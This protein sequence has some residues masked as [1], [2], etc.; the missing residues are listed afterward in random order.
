ML[1]CTLCLSNIGYRKET[2]NETQMPGILLKNEIRYRRTC[3]QPPPAMYCQ[4]LTG[5]Q[6]LCCC[7][8][9][10]SQL[11]TR[12]KLHS[13]ICKSKTVSLSNRK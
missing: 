12:Y 4:V 7:K 8:F 2:D 3:T 11:P 1:T 9:T 13:T 6:L 10:N 5:F